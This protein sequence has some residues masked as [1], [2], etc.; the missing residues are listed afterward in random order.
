MKTLIYPI[1]IKSDSTVI[2]AVNIVPKSRYGVS[3]LELTFAVLETELKETEHATDKHDTNSYSCAMSVQRS[4]DLYFV[5]NPVEKCWGRLDMYR[6][7]DK[8]LA[9][10][11][12][13]QDANDLGGTAIPKCAMCQFG[14]KPSSSTA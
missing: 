11:N 12:S 5:L 6:Y 10:K 1:P 8:E 4:T 14:D 7:C 2:H 3:D 9:A 13:F